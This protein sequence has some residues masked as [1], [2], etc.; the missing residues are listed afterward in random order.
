MEGIIAKTIEVANE[1]QSK[2]S[3]ADPGSCLV[4]ASN[5]L[6]TQARLDMLTDLGKADGTEETSSPEPQEPENTLPTG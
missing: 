2:N 4:A 5:I 1:L 6:T 3:G